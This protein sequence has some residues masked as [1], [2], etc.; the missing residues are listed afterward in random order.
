MAT[1]NPIVLTQFRAALDGLYGNRVERVVLYGSRARGDAQ[2]DSDY[3]VAV[4]LKDLNDRWEEAD[5]IALAAMDIFDET[6]ALI[7]A[8]PYSEGAYQERTPLMHEVRREGVD[9]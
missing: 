7:H 2:D 4:F 3:D 8:M 9:L 6:G 5:K 1:A